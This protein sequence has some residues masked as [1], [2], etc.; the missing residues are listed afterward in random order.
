[1]VYAEGVSG[2]PNGSDRT[3]Q[4]IGFTNTGIG[5][6]GNGGGWEEWEE[7]G[8]QEGG[9]PFSRVKQT[10]AI[11][12]KM[13]LYMGVLACLAKGELPRTLLSRYAR[14]EAMQRAQ[15]AFGQEARFWADG[16][17][18]EIVGRY[19][20]DLADLTLD[21]E[22]PSFADWEGRAVDESDR[23]LEASADGIWGDDDE[24]RA[25][26][27]RHEDAVL[28]A[29]AGRGA[30]GVFDTVL[31]MGSAPVSHQRSAL[32]AG[33][34]SY[35]RP[36]EDGD[37]DDSVARRYDTSKVSPYTP[38]QR[39]SDV[40]SGIVYVDASGKQR[41]AADSSDDDGEDVSAVQVKR[42]MGGLK[43]TSDLSATTPFSRARLLDSELQLQLFADLATGSL[44][45]YERPGGDVGPSASDA[46][47]IDA[48]RQ[49]FVHPTFDAFLYDENDEGARYVVGNQVREFEGSGAGLA[50]LTDLAPGS[51]VRLS[52]LFRAYN[53]NDGA[54]S[55]VIKP[56]RVAVFLKALDAG[57][58]AID[59]IYS[60]ASGEPLVVEAYRTI[61]PD[62]GDPNGR[63]SHELV[64]SG[65]I[66]GWAQAPDAEFDEDED[67]FKF[68]T[69]AYGLHSA[70]RRGLGFYFDG[71][72]ENGLPR[73]LHDATVMPQE[74]HADRNIYSRFEIR[75]SETVLLLNAPLPDDLIAAL[76][77]GVTRIR[78]HFR[79]RADYADIRESAW[80][81]VVTDYVIADGVSRVVP[82]IYVGEES[83]ADRIYLKDIVVVIVPPDSSDSR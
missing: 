41:S 69:G 26:M 38:W 77:P 66:S 63:V 28:A 39:A 67:V 36:A 43:R 57:G 64:V 19:A 16:T 4:G 10:W 21:K 45:A 68:L 25:R 31:P 1:M 27:K 12:T 9:A 34:S 35:Y 30:S 58:T 20:K 44:L 54:D 23:I 79:P 71:A 29:N 3:A 74:Y 18:D 75:G 55:G 82:M 14:S 13:N 52:G 53:E 78:N 22:H 60:T 24:E 65:S 46:S 7:R 49:D 8:F 15:S 81:P 17:D 42:E 83:R 59:P 6:G 62:D 50:D 5:V 73:V 2:R 56:A 11:E 51:R 72:M 80:C 32:G 61:Q 33:T 40:L 37:P 48:R 76:V 70:A 47:R